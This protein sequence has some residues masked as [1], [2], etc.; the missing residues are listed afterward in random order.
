VIVGAEADATTEEPRNAPP[1]TNAAIPI[2][3]SRLATKLVC[4]TD[5]P[6]VHAARRRHQPNPQHDLRWCTDSRSS[7][8]ERSVISARLAPCCDAWTNSPM[9]GTRRDTG[10][11]TGT[12]PVRRSQ[13]ADAGASAL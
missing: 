2:I 7:T 3:P 9:D 10:Q 4:P 1:T 12:D 5:L 6:L 11:L 8:A 13:R